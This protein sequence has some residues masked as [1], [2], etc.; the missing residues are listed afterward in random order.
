MH[1]SYISL[2]RMLEKRAAEDEE[3]RQLFKRN[4]KCTLSDG[5]NLSDEALLAK[6]HA[7]GLNEVDRQWLD[8]STKK[9]P[10]VQALATAITKHSNLEIPDNQ[11]DW[12]W[13]SLVCLWQRWFPDRPNFEMLDDRMQQG[14]D[15]Y[16][17]NEA[18]ETAQ[19]WLQAWRNIQSLMQAFDIS[20][21]QE[22]DDRFGGTQCVFNWVQD[23]SDALHWAART[24]PS[25]ARERIAVCRAV[26]LLG[27]DSERDASL[28]RSFRR[29]LAVSHA[30]L[31]EFAILDKLYTQWMRDDPRWGWGWIGWADIYFLFAPRDHKDPAKAERILKDGLSVSGVENREDILERLAILCEETGRRTEGADLRAEVDARKHRQRANEPKRNNDTSEPDLDSS[32]DLFEG[33]VNERLTDD[34][35][36]QPTGTV[37]NTRHKVGRNDPC[38]CGSGKKYKKCCGAG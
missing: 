38:P 19:L 27:N 8:E 34:D 36:W 32:P 2:N 12:V 16:D 28:I 7:L 29:D 6:L 10:C 21:I 4:G 22:F 33:G 23:F 15:A 18:L 37:R 25:F 9:Y 30:D 31:G 17:R 26:L 5:R 13:I 3:T 14:Y 1:I 35:G 20:N 24:E 11:L